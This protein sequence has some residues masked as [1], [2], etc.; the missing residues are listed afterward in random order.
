MV[1]WLYLP[2]QTCCSDSLFRC[3]LADILLPSSHNCANLA[4]NAMR[5]IKEPILDQY[6]QKH[7]RAAVSLLQWRIVVREL[8]WRSFVDLRQTYRKA[9]AVKVNSGRVV[10]IFDIAGGRFRL[11]TAIN[12]Q[13]GTIV[14]LNFLTHAEYDKQDWKAEF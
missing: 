10:T 11:L 9:D 14:I 4:S 6:A 1:R 7:A 8:R 3:Y 5:I 2:Q 12:Y 13:T